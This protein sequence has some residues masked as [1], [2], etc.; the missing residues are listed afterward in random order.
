MPPL[1]VIAGAFRVALRWTNGSGSQHAVNVVHIDGGSATENDI[2]T[3]LD[4][5]VVANL[6]APVSTQCSVE[7]V[8]VTR[9]DGTSATQSFRTGT[10][11]KWTGM[12][13]TDYSPQVA[14][15]VKLTTVSRGRSHR[16]RIFLPFVGED[17]QSL[18]VITPPSG[19]NWQSNWTDFLAA[20]V[21]AG[22]PLVVASYKLASMETVSHATTEL[23]SATQRRRQE[24]VR[25]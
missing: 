18:G 11:T 13:S 7:Q 20:L 3:L 15:L 6:W 10:P 12:A 14:A 2:F 25:S 9:L 5:H 19:S 1:P 23:F 8:D 21:T 22:K 16:G 4:S 17:V 24:R